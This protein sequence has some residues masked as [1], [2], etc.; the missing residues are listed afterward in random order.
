MSRV[1]R[2]L[3]VVAVLSVICGLIAAG[4]AVAADPDPMAGAPEVGACYD[5]TVKQAYAFSSPEAPVDCG[6]RHTVAVSAVGQLPDSLDWA[7]VDRTQ[8][9]AA[10]VKAVNSTCDPAIAALVGSPTRRALSLYTNFWFAPSDADIAAG[11]RWFSCEV[12]LAE[13]HSLRPL[14]SGQPGKLGRPVAKK[15][16][17]CGDSKGNYVVCTKRHQWRTTY[18]TKVT[19]KPTDR[20]ILR[21]AVRIC[22]R[23]VSSRAWRYGSPIRNGRT[24]FVLI[25]MSQTRR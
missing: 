13:S 18:A 23:H 5:L 16:A 2:A 17:R 25:C 21:A 15:V 10:L 7:S 8:L 24:S 4:S 22:P 20:Q 9:P 6:S 19:A 3:G 12:A 14:A 11:A 1:L